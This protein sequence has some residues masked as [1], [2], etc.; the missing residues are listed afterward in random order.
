IDLPLSIWNW[1]ASC[2]GLIVEVRRQL[3]PIRPIVHARGFIPRVP[4]PNVDETAAPQV[5]VDEALV[6][7]MGS[8]LLRIRRGQRREWLP[9]VVADERL[10]NL[11]DKIHGRLEVAGISEENMLRFVETHL[12][13]TG[14]DDGLVQREIRIETPRNIAKAREGG[15]CNRIGGISRPPNT[16]VTRIG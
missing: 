15:V 1:E 9:V 4:S 5:P 2:C 8:G 13:P 12:C 16:R 6:L 7:E 14:K 3:P 11:V 10:P